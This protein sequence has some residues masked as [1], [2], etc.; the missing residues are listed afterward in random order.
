MHRSSQLI[1]F[2]ALAVASA[3]VALT[4]TSCTKK[5]DPTSS[6]DS[7]K[8]QVNQQLAASGASITI[9]SVSCPSDIEA[10]AGVTFTCTLNLSNGGTLQVKGTQVDDNGKFNVEPVGDVTGGSTAGGATPTTG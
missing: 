1:R 5:L 8:T 2:A 6:A 3:G 10:K 7:I 9:S 4:A